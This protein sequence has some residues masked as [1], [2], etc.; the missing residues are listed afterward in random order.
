VEILSGGQDEALNELRKILKDLMQENHTLRGLLRSLAGFIGDGAGGLLPKLGWDMSDFN[1]FVNRSETDT[2]WESY[3]LRKKSRA[4]TAASS[5]SG[6]APSTPPTKRAAEDETATANGRTKRPRVMTDSDKDKNASRSGPD[7]SLLAPLNA[8]VPPVPNNPYVS[9]SPIFMHQPSPS[10]STL[11]GAS[12]SSFSQ[13]YMSP[14]SV[15]V[16]P[17]LPPLSFSPAQN[18]TVPNRLPQSQ[19]QSQQSPCL[20]TGE[21]DE[22]LDA[23][24]ETYKLVRYHLENYKRN[25]AYCLPASLRPTLLQRT[26][27]HESIIDRIVHPE[28]RD[29]IILLRSQIDLVDCLY[30]YSRAITVHGDDVLAHANWEIGESWLRQY[31]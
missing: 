25:S 7:Y 9:G 28:L 14:M 30:D 31:G 17:N 12:S 15:N 16:D 23:N 21:E 3:Q 26:M 2:A 27:P 20:K 19:S 24:S 6:P 11:R 29:R 13:G 10:A 4:E 8:S 22:T 1:K 18:G 5:S